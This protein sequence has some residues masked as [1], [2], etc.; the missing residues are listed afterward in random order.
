MRGN[1]G[2]RAF[3]FFFLGTK[4][5]AR[6]SGRKDRLG[7]IFLLLFSFNFFCRS[8]VL[9]SDRIW[10]ANKTKTNR[11]PSNLIKKS[12]SSSSSLLVLP[13][14]SRKI[15]RWRLWKKTNQ[16]TDA[17][18]KRGK[19]SSHLTAHHMGKKGVN[20]NV[21]I[22][23]N[24][25]IFEFSIW[26]NMRVDAWCAKTLFPPSS[27]PNRGGRAWGE[28]GEGEE[29]R[30]CSIFFALEA[31]PPPPPSHYLRRSRQVN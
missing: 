8:R 1:R 23:L 15:A 21:L 31:P 24:F 13:F 18:K 29:R 9:H 4:L 11:K 2:V 16:E 25:W 30:R 10:E 28:E 5:D 17:S 22:F 12:S 6:P 7:L 3:A 19:S 26:R 14:H 27:R 20:S